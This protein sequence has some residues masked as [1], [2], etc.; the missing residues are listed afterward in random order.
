MTLPVELQKLPPQAL[1]VIRFLK[2]YENGAD[3]GTILSGTGLS[4]RA[5]G[6][7]I[8]RLV[9]RHY[10]NM[11][12]QNTYALTR[13]GH[14]AAEEI[15]VFD[16]A[17]PA[18]VTHPAAISAEEA[19]ADVQVP[20]ASDTPIICH[21][22][23]LSVLVAHEMVMGMRSVVLIG[24]DSPAPDAPAMQEPGQLV[25]RLS[26]PGCNIEPVERPL[27]VAV[28]HAVG[29]VQFR[30]QPRLEGPLRIKIEASQFINAL[31]TVPIGGIFFDLDV[32]PFPTSRSA[33]F[34]ALGAMVE[35][36]ANVGTVGGTP[37]L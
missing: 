22:R 16:G 15:Q 24:F 13:V 5:F 4:E 21:P 8:R 37:E 18:A 12:N 28:D 19:P 11:P 34:Q 23:R 6:K 31:D 36:I 2:D 25:L 20:L 17:E 1:D 30:V 27:E 9:T 32:V 14:E 10:V 35:L 26:A 3:V 7:A 33:E 29:P